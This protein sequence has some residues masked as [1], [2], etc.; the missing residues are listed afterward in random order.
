[1]IEGEP[2]IADVP[3]DGGEPILT[4]RQERHLPAHPLAALASGWDGLPVEL[5][6]TATPPRTP[7]RSPSR[8]IAQ[9]P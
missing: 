6:A 2:T 4:C 1:M 8:T 5:D 3:F 7:W 9:K